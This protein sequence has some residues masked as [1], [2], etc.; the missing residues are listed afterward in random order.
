M[1]RIGFIGAGLIG[2]ERVRAAKMLMQAGYPLQSVGVL[3]SFA[4]DTKELR[5]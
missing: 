2:K 4:P 1:I 3:D 5:E